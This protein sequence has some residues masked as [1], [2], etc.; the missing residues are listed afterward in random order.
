MAVEISREAQFGAGSKG[1]RFALRKDEGLDQQIYEAG[2]DLEAKRFGADSI[3][4]RV[5]DRLSANGHTPPMPGSNG[6]RQVQPP[7]AD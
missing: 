7:A 5:F 2:R 1:F 4:R 3:A 6:A